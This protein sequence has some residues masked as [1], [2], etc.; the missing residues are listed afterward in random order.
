MVVRGPLFV[1]VII[2]V[3]WLLLT[4][5]AHAQQVPGPLTGLVG[6]GAPLVASASSTPSGGLTADDSQAAASAA[7]PPSGAVSPSAAGGSGPLPTNPGTPPELGFPDI[8]NPFDLLSNLDPREWA[9]DILDAVVTAI[10]RALLEGMR[11][12]IDWALGFGDSSLNF[13]TRTPAAGSTDSTTVRALWDFSRAVANAGL[14]LIVM[15]G[16]FNIVVKEHTRSPYHGVME[17][18]PRVVLAALALNLTLE[19]ARL[20]IDVNNAFTA[21]VGQVGLPGYEAASS[22]QEGIAL[23]LLA[24]TYGVVAL[25]L[26]FQMLMRLALIDVLIVLAPVMM[27]L[28]VLPQTQSWTRWWAHLFPITVFQ[29]AVQMVVL[30]LG[31]A[32]MVELTPGSVSNALLTLLLG[33]AICW[34][35]LKV[36]SLL[37]SQVQ[38]AGL[39]S[40][41]SLVVVGRAAGALASRGGAGAST[42]AAGAAR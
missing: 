22:Q 35:T 6:A 3:S 36:P 15:W 37:R 11:E 29:Q 42:A 31:A 4:A 1:V 17:L 7:V 8:P 30:R 13:V 32:L 9:G 5:P 40:V 33:I 41:V 23:V 26:V 2:V 12:F 39:S 19:L 28:W 21:A 18:L 14:A 27:L 34:L 25:L 20:L 16:G 38:H 24:I 10:G